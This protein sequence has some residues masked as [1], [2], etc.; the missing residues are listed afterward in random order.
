MSARTATV[1]LWRTTFG[2]YRRSTETAERR[3]TAVRGVRCVEA[4]T[5]GA[6]NRVLILQLGTDADEAKVFRAHA[7]PQGLR[8]NLINALKLLANQKTD[9]DSPIQSI[10]TGL[11]ER[12]RKGIMDGLRSFVETDNH[13][14][15]DVVHLRR[16]LRPFYVQK[17]NVSEVYLEAIREGADDLTNREMSRAAGVKKPNESPK[18]NAL[19]AMKAAKDREEEF[20]DPAR[21]D[22]ILGRKQTRLEL[23]EE[24]LKCQE[25][26][27]YGCPLAQSSCE[28]LRERQWPAVGR[29]Q[30]FWPKMWE[31]PFW[32]GVWPHLDPWDSLRL[33]TASTHWNVPV[34][35]GPHGEHF[36]FLIKKEQVVASNEVLQIPFV[37]AETLKACALIGLHLL[38]AG[39]DGSSCSQSP[40]LGDM[41]R[42]GCPKS[43]DWDGNVELW[44]ESEGT[45]SS[46]QCEH[47]V[48]S[49]ALNVM[50]QDQSGENISLF[51]ED[52]ELARVALSCHIALDLLCQEMQ[53]A[54]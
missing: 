51:L 18:A 39:E 41:W 54:W 34:K 36:F 14:A 49:L 4:N 26:P 37:S 29:A 25:N 53:E 9:G 17:P 10:V 27:Y 38:A 6:P 11:Q 48:E 16:S 45:S 42:Y 21:K 23:W 22:K 46:G 28:K 7:A 31:G 2:G 44:T 20:Y 24:H 32:K 8:E 30:A 33:R 19:W 35:Y 43:P 13:S 3:S 5:N 47:N 40:D 50:R 15:V 1:F 52:W 12:S